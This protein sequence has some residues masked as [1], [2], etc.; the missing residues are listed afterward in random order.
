M[1]VDSGSGIQRAGIGTVQ[2]DFIIIASD[3][4]LG[5]FGIPQKHHWC[6]RGNDGVAGRMHRNR[7]G[8]YGV[9]SENR[10]IPVGDGQ[11]VI[12]THTQMIHIAIQ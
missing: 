2:I 8:G 12:N 1:F 11:F 9:H 5:V 10:R 7:H 6:V 4:I 3:I